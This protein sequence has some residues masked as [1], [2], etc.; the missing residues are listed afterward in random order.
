MNKTDKQAFEDW[1]EAGTASGD[2]VEKMDA[3]KGW[4]AALEFRDAQAA[5]G[6]PVPWADIVSA[7][8]AVTKEASRR[9][10]MFPQES[11]A[12]SEDRAASRRVC[13]L[14]KWYATCGGSVAE[15][16]D[17]WPKRY[18]TPQPAP[19]VQDLIQAAS[20]ALKALE[21]ADNALVEGQPIQINT[22]QAIAALQAT[23][24]KHGG[25]DA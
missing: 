15:E 19:D 3:L 13:E 17:G 12:H 1:F 14:I 5:Q 11:K 4:E 8:R 10:E 22:Q 9:G 18:T 20:E 23:L 21:W 2:G 25:C 24:A 6:E 7:I 16:L